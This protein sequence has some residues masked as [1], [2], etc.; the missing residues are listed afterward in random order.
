[1]KDQKQSLGQSPF[2]YVVSLWPIHDIMCVR[3]D[4]EVNQ[5]TTSNMTKQEA[6]KQL[7]Q[8]LVSYHLTIPTRVARVWLRHARVGSTDSRASTG[9]RTSLNGRV[10]AEHA[11][12]RAKLRSTEGDHMLANVLS[13]NLTVLRVGV[14]KDVLNE[15]VA[16]L[17]TCDVN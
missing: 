9:T 8:S 4:R 14:C 3:K 1:M 7:E 17:V 12:T 6:K 13:D 16:V 5:G 2:E 11:N 15:V 10:G